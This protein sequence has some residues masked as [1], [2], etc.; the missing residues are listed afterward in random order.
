MSRTF[1]PAPLFL[2]LALAAGA[3]STA[4]AGPLCDAVRPVVPGR[5]CAESEHGVALAFTQER[6][7][8]LLSF[9]QRGEAEF[10]ARFGVAPTRYVVSETGANGREV[11]TDAL[12]AAGFAVVVPWRMRQAQINAEID[13][14]QKRLHEVMAMNGMSDAQI[15]SAMEQ[16]LARLR[17]ER[18]TPEA[19]S[20]NEAGAIPRMLAAGWFARAFWPDLAPDPERHASPAPDWMDEVAGQLM[21]TEAMA[22]DKR[23]QF[24]EVYAGR[25]R[26][27][28][29]S[30]AAKL[31][32]LPAFL[33]AEH[34]ARAMMAAQGGP[35]SGPGSALGGGAVRITMGGPGGGPAQ[36]MPAPLM[37]GL[38]ARMFADY[39]V[40]KT[41]DRAIF[42]RLGQAFG[43]GTAFETWLAAD[44][45]ALGLAPTVE[46]VAADWRT[47]LQGRLGTPAA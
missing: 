1:R 22:E 11:R 27:A 45:A 33:S 39:L 46:G 36:S 10:Q 47:W 20:A 28:P 18:H 8:E 13:A 41:G 44:G 29:A 35:V 14:L 15:A 32:D 30:D 42:G 4:Q 2:G 21:E 37:Y 9:A 7:A 19:M 38:Q 3:A 16:P 12:R 43:A 23:T 31:T 24:A 34:P 26:M 17:Q 40:E 6:A 5:P 25:R